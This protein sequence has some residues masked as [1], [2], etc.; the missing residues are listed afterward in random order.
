M[1]R[2]FGT[3]DTTFTSNGDAAIRPLKAKVRKEG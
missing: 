2:V 3:A 1:I